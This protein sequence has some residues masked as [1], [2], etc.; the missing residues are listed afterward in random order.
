M[1]EAADRMMTTAVIT[2]QFSGRSPAARAPEGPDRPEDKAALAQFTLE[3][4]MAYGVHHP[5]AVE[6]R[7]R[8]AAGQEWEAAAADLAADCLAPPEGPVAPASPATEANRL[9]RA[10]A[11]LR[12]SQ[13]MMLSDDDQRRDIFSR[14]ADLYRRAAVLTGDRE[15]VLVETEEGPLVGWRFPSQGG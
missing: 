4:L 15:R 7:G 3:R 12:M 10:S 13:V 9:F 5:D 6:F 2:H 11:L 8:V 1:G 14:A